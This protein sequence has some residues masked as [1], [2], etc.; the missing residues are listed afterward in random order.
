MLQPFLGYI[1]N[2][3]N[4]FYAQGFTALEFPVNPGR[5]RRCTTTSGS[6]TSS[7]AVADPRHRLV[8]AIAPTFEV[9]VNTPL[10]HRDVFNPNDPAG[11][12]DVVNLTYG[13]NFEFRQKSLL[14]F[15][16]VNPVTGPRPF[17]YEVMLLF[18]YRFGRGARQALPPVTSG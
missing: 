17:A 9:H 16:F 1:W 10:N 5:S 4:R 11:S 15:G 14:T 13:M 18:N 7:T 8:T 6:A 2:P 3:G 12:A